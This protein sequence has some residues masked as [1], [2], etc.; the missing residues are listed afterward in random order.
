MT[1]GDAYTR[2]LDLGHTGYPVTDTEGKLAGIVTRRDLSRHVQ[3]GRGPEILGNV[4]SGLC[5]T[6]SPDEVLHR[7]RDRMFQ[8]DVGRL[9]I[10]DPKDRRQIVGILTRSDLLRAEAEKDVEHSDFFG[11]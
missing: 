11:A 3:A 9:V 6:G 8:Q 7:A 5:I 10:V 2:M 1:V 4:V